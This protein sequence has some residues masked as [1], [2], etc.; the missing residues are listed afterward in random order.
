M[1]L[2]FKRNFEV[3]WYAPNSYLKI[4]ENVFLNV[5]KVFYCIFRGNLNKSIQ[6][7]LFVT[8]CEILIAFILLFHYAW[9][10]ATF[11]GPLISVIY[12]LKRMSSPIRSFSELWQY[13]L[14]YIYWKTWIKVFKV[15]FLEFL[16]KIDRALL[17]CYI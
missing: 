11:S 10:R 12:V 17:F 3:K 9:K 7:H 16:W 5:D 1:F 14:L 8:F 4:F 2:Y 6:N 13:I 15:I